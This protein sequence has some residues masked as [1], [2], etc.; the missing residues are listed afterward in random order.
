MY[1]ENDTLTNDPSEAYTYS[2]IVNIP[3]LR[4]TAASQTLFTPVFIDYNGT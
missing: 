3:I 1:D 4:P 2:W